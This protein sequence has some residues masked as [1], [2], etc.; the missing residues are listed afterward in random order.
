MIILFTITSVLYLWMVGHDLIKHKEIK[1]ITLNYG[2]L[3]ITLGIITL[4]QMIK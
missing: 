1:N 2:L 3:N 4:W